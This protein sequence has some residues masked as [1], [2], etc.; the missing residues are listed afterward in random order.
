MYEPTDG[1]EDIQLRDSEMENTS[2]EMKTPFIDISQRLSS[3]RLESASK[4]IKRLL[5]IGFSLGGEKER[6]KEIE[7]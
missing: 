3:Q 4:G 7:T 6:F 5:R 1:L 2:I